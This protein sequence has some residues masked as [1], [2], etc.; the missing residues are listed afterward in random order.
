MKQHSD[1]YKLSAVMYYIN[2]NEDLRD[3][4]D[5]FKC[6][7]QS[8]HRWI[9]RYKLQG[10]IRRKTRKNH[11]LK[12][13]PEIEN[14]VKEQVKRDPTT[15]LWE[16]SKLVN[17]EFNVI[18]TDRSINNILNRM[19]ITRKRLRSKYYPEKREGQEK[20]DLVEFYNKL[21]DYD[22]RKTICMDET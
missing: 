3:T 17:D 21:N 13:T 11:N 22:Y 15:T 18:L 1:D 20:Q 5:I 12:I 19:K 7:Y 4:C 9:K 8:L 10:D 2:H 6:K 16:Y 14:F